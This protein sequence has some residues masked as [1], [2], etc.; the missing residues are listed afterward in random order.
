LWAG[1]AAGGAGRG[2]AE[3]RGR[4]RAQQLLREHFLTQQSPCAG[5]AAALRPWGP[6]RLHC[7]RADE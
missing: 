2:V 4:G 6:P 5:R 1:P 7:P 3:P